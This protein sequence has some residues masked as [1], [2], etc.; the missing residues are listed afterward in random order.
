MPFYAATGLINALTS[1]VLGAFVFA[2]NPKQPVNCKYALFN[3]MVAIWSYGYFFWQISG[4]EHEAL[5]WARVLI[6]GAIL[7]PVTFLDFVVTWLNV[8]ERNR[9]YLLLSYILSF[10]F[11]ILDF[12]P[13][14]VSAVEA[15]N[16]FSY[17]PVPGVAFHFALAL[18]MINAIY[19]CYLLSQALVSSSGVWKSQ[20][21]LA[22]VGMIIGYVGGSTNYFLWYDI[23]IPPIGNGLAPIYMGMMTYA[24]LRYKAMDIEVIIKRTLVFTGI[25]AAAAGLVSLPLAL[26]QMVLG[27]AVGTPPFL[28]MASGIVTAV[29]VYR[30]LERWLTGITDRFLFQKKY[31]FN[32]V[33]REA[34]EKITN[35][36]DE[37]AILDFLVDAL[38]KET[39]IA[40]VAVYPYDPGRKSYRQAAQVGFERSILP[41][42]LEEGDPLMTMLRMRRQPVAGSDDGEEGHSIRDTLARWKVQLAVPNLV[43]DRLVAVWLLGE[44]LSDEDYTNEDL[45]MISALASQAALA[46]ENARNKQELIRKKRLEH[47]AELVRGFAH[48][49]KNPLTGLMHDSERLET[50][51]F[52]SVYN[53]CKKW[54]SGEPHVRAEVNKVLRSFRDTTKSFR[55]TLERVHLIVD[56]LHQMQ[57]GDDATVLFDVGS[58]VNESLSLAGYELAAFSDDSVQ[59]KKVIQ[60]NLPPVSGIPVLLHEVVVNLYKNALHAMAGSNE[61]VITVRVLPDERQ[62]DRI[63]V[64][65]Q[66]T[67]RGMS[68][69]TRARLFEHGFTTKGEQGSGMGLYRCKKV[70]EG[71]GGEISVESEEG[72]GST[73]IIS[74]PA[75]QKEVSSGL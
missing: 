45:V 27:R 30:P 25:V 6:G 14:I 24:I 64:R 7:I 38:N 63:L 75:A 28:L 34:S 53:L 66:D 48:D 5:F 22:L 42:E 37:K 49:L 18:F 41:A 51:E 4:H 44:K 40:R 71:F 65:F 70:I 3:L 16:V 2:K 10:L 33:L 23:Q 39:R 62:S 8:Y 32:A 73:F 19:A 54:E 50:E 15:R 20:V 56:T 31:D 55:S 1:T 67:G 68:H 21:R 35:L 59:V 36:A 57:K 12:T 72:N 58:L 74:L 47:I 9:R 29:L 11:V 69:D 52:L 26:L 43:E 46:L 60:P 61:R 17:W 13:H